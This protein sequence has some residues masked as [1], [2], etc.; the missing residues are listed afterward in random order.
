MNGYDKAMEMAE[1]T[2][3][4]MAAFSAKCGHN[5]PVLTWN[6]IKGT[7]K[8]LLEEGGREHSWRSGKYKDIVEFRSRFWKKAID[9][10]YDVDSNFD[11]VVEGWHK[12]FWDSANFDVDPFPR[13]FR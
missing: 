6:E 10:M 1:E 12:E 11:S 9:S 13:S 7:I 4:L 2:Y 5:K 8:G 3:K